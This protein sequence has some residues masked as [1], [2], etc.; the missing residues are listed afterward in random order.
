MIEMSGLWSS[1]RWAIDEKE[2]REK[3]KLFVRLSQSCNLEKRKIP[4][5]L[6]VPMHR[7]VGCFFHDGC[8]VFPPSDFLPDFL[9]GDPL[10][11]RWERAIKKEDPREFTQELKAKATRVRL[12]RIPG[13]LSLQLQ[14]HWRRPR[15]TIPPPRRNRWTRFN[16]R[17]RNVVARRTHY[18]IR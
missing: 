10:S 16:G 2:E 3:R 6:A 14:F 12:N 17:T 13:C 1:S 18:S 4:R 7:V 11:D 9:G 15:F 5:E 8:V